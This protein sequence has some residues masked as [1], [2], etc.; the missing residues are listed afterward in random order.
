M[1]ERQAWQPFSGIPMRMGEDGNFAP[2]PRSF[3]GVGHTLHRQD[4]SQ[5]VP[6]GQPEETPE[7][8][9][10]T[11]AESQMIRDTLTDMARVAEKWQMEAS[12]CLQPENE[13]SD[14]ETEVARKRLQKVEDWLTA[15]FM[16]LSSIEAKDRGEP[17]PET[18][19]RLVLISNMLG[20]EFQDLKDADNYGAVAVVE[21]PPPGPM[22]SPQA[23]W[24]ALGGDSDSDAESRFPGATQE[25]NEDGT[26]QTP[27]TRAR[28]IL[29]SEG[30]EDSDVERPPMV[31][32]S[33]LHEPLPSTPPTIRRPYNS[34]S[35]PAAAT[36]T[37]PV[38]SP[39]AAHSS[40]TCDAVPAKRRRI[41][42]K[43]PDLWQGAGLD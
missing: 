15:A 12:R 8:V 6:A 38:A 7:L 17:T 32:T 28:T 14:L 29:S 33:F 27:R 36:D 23:L 40:A 10:L 31:A 4:S 39:A 16:C 25:Y 3:S 20:Q 37:S 1:V 5:S 35:P 19:E 42:G 13:L 18:D 34:P 11:A 22:V 30:E 41:S 2:V 21:E 26:P 9:T 24:D 43:Q